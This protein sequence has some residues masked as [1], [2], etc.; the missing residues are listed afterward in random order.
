MMDRLS[1]KSSYK[2]FKDILPEIF[3]TPGGKISRRTFSVMLT[4]EEIEFVKTTRKKMWARNNGDVI[5]KALRLYNMLKDHEM[6]GSR[7]TV[8]SPFGKMG[9]WLML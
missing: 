6:E 4:E 2:N 9:M 7:L 3:S 5:L 1:R 8:E